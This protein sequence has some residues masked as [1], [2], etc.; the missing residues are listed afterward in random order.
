MK[1]K[2]IN[3]IKKIVESDEKEV[4][5]VASPTYVDAIKERKSMKDAIENRLSKEFKNLDKDDAF[6]GSEPREITESKRFILSEDLF[7]DVCEDVAVMDPPVKVRKQRTF[8]PIFDNLYDE[9]VQRLCNEYL[10]TNRGDKLRGYYNIEDI[11]EMEDESKPG[12]LSITVTLPYVSKD[13]LNYAIAVAKSYDL[14]YVVKDDSPYFKKRYSAVTMW[15][16]ENAEAR[17]KFTG[18]KDGKYIVD[19]VQ[20]KV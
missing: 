10:F 20:V 13:K 7:R 8:K 9:V 1:L 4:Q 17:T 5:A 6:N 14:E 18:F 15:V 11:Q 2:M 12:F 3:T 19:K 16:P